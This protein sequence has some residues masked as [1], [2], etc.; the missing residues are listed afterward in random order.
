M[1]CAACGATV[2]LLPDG[3][4]PRFRYVAEVIQQALASYLTA[5]ISYRD[6][7]VQLS[8]A[9]LPDDVSVTD[10]LLSVQLVPSY[11]RI[12]AWVKHLAML[13]VASAQTLTTWILR[14]R[15]DSH[16]FHLFATPIPTFTV[17]SRSEAKRRELRAAALLLAFVHG[18]A[19]LSGAMRSAWLSG[20]STMTRRLQGWPS[21]PDPPGT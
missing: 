15:P 16:L 12:H 10:A 18:T 13:A 11:Q 2:T 9:A 20:L 4:V 5:K 17:R 19:E 7:S 21:L 1:Q 8:G 3:L 14:L 6:L